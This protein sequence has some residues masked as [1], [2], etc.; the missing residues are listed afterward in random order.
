LTPRIHLGHV[1]PGPFREESTHG[2]GQ[3]APVWSRNIRGGEFVR[4]GTITALRIRVAFLS[5]LVVWGLLAP[6][7]E[8]H[9]PLKEKEALVDKALA[10]DA[11]DPDLH[12]RRAK[13][14]RQR[15]NWDAA[16]A[17][18]L[19]AAAL[20]ANRHQVDIALAQVLLEA[21]LPLMAEMYVDR[22]CTDAPDNAA[23]WI[24]RARVRRTLGKKEPSAAD[25]NR[26]VAMLQRPDPDVVREAMAA[27]VAAGHP[28]AA[29]RLADGA[30]EKIGPVAS[31][32]LPAIELE[33]ELGH[34]AAAVRRYDTL[35]EQAPRHEVW[36]AQ[37][38]DILEEM[39]RS[40][41]ARREYTRALALIRKRPPERRSEKIRALERRLEAK[42]A[43]E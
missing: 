42:L 21:D 24:T 13:L 31:V 5:T 23:A 9:P 6:R 20:G 41:E 38:G 33:L 28:E 8:A 27:Q 36:L 25:F 12:L 17:S 37:R 35:L 3:P 19:R 14:H 26:G 30:I 39:G 15:R 18:Y 16:A 34:S 40:D 7:A 32:Q 2:E 4:R 1:S 22:V 43:A 29:L 11:G 10:E